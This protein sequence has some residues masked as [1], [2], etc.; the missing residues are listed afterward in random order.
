[1][2]YLTD[3]FGLRAA[4]NLLR[5][6]HSFED[7]AFRTKVDGD[8][9]QARRLGLAAAELY[10]IAADLLP[11]SKRAQAMAINLKGLELHAMAG[12]WQTTQEATRAVEI[13]RSGDEAVE[14]MHR[15]REAQVRGELRLI[16]LSEN[17]IET[18][19]ARLLASPR[20]LR[21]RIH[22]AAGGTFFGAETINPDAAV[23]N[24]GKTGWC[25]PNAFCPAL[26][27]SNPRIVLDDG[28]VIWGYQCWWGEIDYDYDAEGPKP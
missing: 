26:G 18:A 9:P 13:R 16:G 12:H 28:T 7:A 27:R 21:V 3:D 2:S 5:S 1:M 11:E 4:R 19:L 25:E 10:R 15:R 22:D 20:F 6:A 23:P 17:Q 8:V 14:S 24:I